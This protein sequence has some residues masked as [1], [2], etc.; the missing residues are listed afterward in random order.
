MNRPLWQRRVYFLISIIIFATANHL[1]V[2]IYTLNLVFLLKG[3]LLLPRR[4]VIAIA[5]ISM[6]LGVT[7]FSVRAPEIFE[8][9][10]N[11]D[12]EAY[13]NV[14][15][16]ITNIVM[17]DLSNC[18]FVLLFGNIWVEEQKSRQKAE[19]LTQQVETLAT[20]LER[21]RIARD[22]HDTLGHSLT[23]LDVQIELAQR[24][25]AT[26][27]ARAQQSI[28][29]AKKLSSQAIDNVRQALG[30]MKRSNFDLKE[31]IVALAEQ[32]QPFQIIV[33]LQFP[34]LSL[35]SSYQLYCIVQESLT[36]IQKHAQADRVTIESKI[37]NNGTVLQICDN[38][39]GFSLD[40]PHPGFGLRNMKER[41]Q[42]LGGE[43]HITSKDGQG[44]QIKIFVP[45]SS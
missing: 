38:G 36:N 17:G 3:C 39:N 37:V 10:R 34:Q 24:L 28:D 26:E 27:P 12:I 40:R 11:R 16:I 41:V 15:R 45:A 7:S 8:S 25:Q 33:N 2:P 1:K 44:T 20:D 18:V 43:F 32:N 42:C 31:A 13:L 29:L 22:I 14:P 23:S 19:R 21:N 5:A 30:T 6:V 4:E 35:Q 9:I